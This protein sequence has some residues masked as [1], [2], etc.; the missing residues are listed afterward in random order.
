MVGFTLLAISIAG[1]VIVVKFWREE[2]NAR[3]LQGAEMARVLEAHARATD[4]RNRLTG[5]LVS[6]LQGLDETQKRLVVSID[7]METTHLTGQHEGAVLLE[8]FQR[9][10]QDVE[11]LQREFREIAAAMRAKVRT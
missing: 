1:L 6:T 7:R 9:G 5:A 4:E 11:A 3:A 8:R 10:V 2:S